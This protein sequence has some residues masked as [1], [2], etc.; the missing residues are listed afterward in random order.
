MKPCIYQGLELP[1]FSKN[2]C[3]NVDMISQLPKF[4][5]SLIDYME[6]VFKI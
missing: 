2:Q 6:N 4:L 1:I 5:F 3:E